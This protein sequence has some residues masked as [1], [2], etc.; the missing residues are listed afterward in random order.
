MNII[1]FIPPLLLLA[2]LAYRNTN[3]GIYVIL[4]TIP[5]YLLRGNVWLVPTTWLEL[6]I[7]TVSLISLYKHVRKKTLAP[8]WYYAL[9]DAKHY[10]IP[11]L[12]FSFAALVSVLVSPDQMRALGIIKAWFFDPLLFAILILDKL[13]R[14][15]TLKRILLA[16]SFSGIPIMFYGIF[17]YALGVGLAIPG[18]L[19][20]FFESPNYVSMYLVPL[21][22]MILGHMM[23]DKRTSGKN[24][25]QMNYY[26]LWLVG[27]ATTLI[28]TKSF[29]GWFAA[30]GGIIFLALFYKK[31]TAKKFVMLILISAALIPLGLYGYQKSKTHYNSFWNINSFETRMEVWAHTFRMITYRPITG[32]GLGGFHD[33]YILYI[34][35]LPREKQPIEK[36][37]LWP[38]NIYLAL[39]VESGTLSLAAFI[40]IIL[41]FYSETLRA[42]FKEN[43]TLV[44]PSAAAMTSILLH[45]LIDT[46]YLKNDLSLLFWIIVVFSIVTKKQSM[47]RR[48]DWHI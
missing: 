36:N 31:T 10:I 13:T 28:L 27:S 44:L 7:Y 41:I 38:H 9:H 45:G 6:A 11:A 34:Q 12:I 14:K 30:G 24:R 20:S 39:L 16:L 22:L 21:S 3:Y 2:Y 46:P 40:W 4:A 48:H 23:T 5:G 42:Y 33:E 35:K 8:H 1:F 37:V 15:T 29:G 47:A 19:D 17:E 43:N 18:R 32:V 25:L 26:I